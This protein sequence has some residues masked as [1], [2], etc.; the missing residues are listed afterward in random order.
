V[1]NKKMG[2]DEIY[3]MNINLTDLPSS[4]FPEYDD[5]DHVALFVDEFAIIGTPK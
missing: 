3:Q 5:G 1:P 4:S 2:I